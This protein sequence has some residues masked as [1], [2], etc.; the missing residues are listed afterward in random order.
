MHPPHSGSSYGA[1]WA[2]KICLPAARELEATT[3]FQS[4]SFTC[5]QH[6]TH[7]L[8]MFLH[9]LGKEKNH[10]AL[11]QGTLHPQARLSMFKSSCLL[12]LQGIERKG[13]CTQNRG[14]RRWGVGCLL[15]FRS[16][17]GIG[18][19]RVV[20][21]RVRNTTGQCKE[22]TREVIVGGGQED[23]DVPAVHPC[24]QSSSRAVVG[25]RPCS[26]AGPWS[27]S[28]RPRLNDDI[29]AKISHSSHSITSR[30]KV[31]RTGAHV[32]EGM[33]SAAAALARLLS[34]EAA[35]ARV[36]SVAHALPSLVSV[37]VCRVSCVVCRVSCVVC[38][39]T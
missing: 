28:R 30:Q 8:Y 21:H 39:S 11:Q 1:S 2:E 16:Q 10:L 18:G 33:H 32:L 20:L 3:S 23:M 5:K 24:P 35:T 26:W 37:V 6:C 31:G 38:V 4:K 29:S 22:N 25:R 9:H 27:S 14:L 12:W 17:L 7:A 36:P 19:R 34:R 15:L 13:L